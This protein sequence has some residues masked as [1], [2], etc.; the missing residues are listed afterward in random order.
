MTK[1]NSRA[2]INANAGKN[3]AEK[4]Q[5][6]QIHTW[7]KKQ[8]SAYSRSLLALQCIFIILFVMQLLIFWQV[9]EIAHQIIVLKQALTQ[10]S[11]VYLSITLLLFIALA[12]IKINHTSHLQ[13][14]IF[15][16]LQQKLNNQLQTGQYA[17][18]NQQS[19]YYWQQLWLL[20]LPA[21]S[22]FTTKYLP[23]KTLAT[24]TPFIVLAVV[25]PIHWLVGV[26]LIV[27]MPIVPMFM[28]IVGKGAASL[29]QQHFTAL[30]RLGSV[31]VDRL[32]ALPLLEIFNAHKQQKQVLQQASEHVNNRTMKV[33]SV[34]FLSTTVLDFFSTISV[35]LVAVF[36][37]FNLL[38]EINI[39]KQLDL[40]QGL[41][42]L[43]V[44]PLIFAEL[45]QLGRLYHQ[46]SAA[47]A[48][49]Q[50]LMPLLIEHTQ[51]EAQ[52][53][54]E[55]KQEQSNKVTRSF[56]GIDWS[57]FSI[58]TPPIT[59]KKIQLNVGDW[60][61]LQGASG[62]GKTVLMEALMA[63]R[64]ASHTLTAKTAFL[65]QHAVITP[66]S[67]RDNLCLGRNIATEQL[68]KLLAQVE[69]TQW[70]KA[71]PDQ[72]ETLMGEQPPLSGGQKQRLALARILLVNADV[73]FLDEPTAH[74]TDEQH[75]T[76]SLLIRQCFKNKTVIWASHKPLNSTWFTQQWRMHNFTLEVL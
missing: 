27:T 25:F 47:V 48:A 14:K 29:Q 62:S 70:T 32:K 10:S 46:K 39:G 69:L 40:S 6:K 58:D 30:E 24:V 8:G 20:H 49:A 21:I 55:Q 31:F 4:N 63:W 34:A 76:L 33:V 50:E 41:F 59:A 5:V 54:I 51:Q 13:Q 12:Y 1:T 65:S 73:I 74:L 45:K 2:A 60:V 64:S 43:L 52:Q 75:Q 61:Q 9:A 44:A 23:Q 53:D 3:S 26:V 28:I 72:L 15:G 35:A 17:L 16:H 36:V 18:V 68:W 19:S 57:D 38:G 66:N 71:L 42:L 7:L 37:G 67:L 56:N 11:L 22:D